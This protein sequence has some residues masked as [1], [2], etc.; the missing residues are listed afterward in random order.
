MEY[1]MRIK[2]NKRQL[3]Q[4]I[5]TLNEAI[6]T[7]YQCYDELENMGVLVVDEAEEKEDTDSGN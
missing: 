1:I 5:D 4:T 6:K 3:D 7:I 2:F